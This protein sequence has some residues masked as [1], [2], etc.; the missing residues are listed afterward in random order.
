[1]NW[2]SVRQG[3]LTLNA[4]LLS[5]SADRY[6][7][8]SECIHLLHALKNSYFKKWKVLFPSI[9]SMIF[10][11]LWAWTMLHSWSSSR[12][13]SFTFS[14]KILT[15]IRFSYDFGQ[16]VVEEFES[17]RVLFRVIRIKYENPHKHYNYRK[18]WDNISYV[19]LKRDRRRDHWNSLSRLFL[20]EIWKNN[21]SAISKMRTILLT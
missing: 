13:L 12:I 4:G 5:S 21:E 17:L 9:R 18:E 3:W 8:F 10:R 15:I 14:Q 11:T 2:A 19:V 1:M 7:F 20:N 16:I 6:S